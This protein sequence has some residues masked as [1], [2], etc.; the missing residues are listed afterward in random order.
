MCYLIKV[1]NDV[2]EEV[3]TVKFNNNLTVEGAPDYVNFNGQVGLTRCTSERYKDELVIMYFYPEKQEDSYAEFISE[4]EA[5]NLCAH[6]NKLDV[7]NEL[8]I[9]LLHERGVE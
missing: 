1:L 3:D 2:N 9:N 8:N 5:Y 7:A 4:L 6:R